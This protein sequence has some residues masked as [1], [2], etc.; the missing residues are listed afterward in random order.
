MNMLD[1]YHPKDVYKIKKEFI[2]LALIQ[3][4]YYCENLVTLFEK[5]IVQ[6]T[7]YNHIL[8]I[9][10]K[11]ELEKS[12]KKMLT[13][14]ELKDLAFNRKK[15]ESNIV[16]TDFTSVFGSKYKKYYNSIFKKRIIPYLRNAI[17]H[18]KFELD[19]E[20]QMIKGIYNPTTKRKENISFLKFIDLHDTIVMIYLCIVKELV[21]GKI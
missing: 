15:S 8:L 16:I 7:R 11:K 13:Y 17:A 19:E 20:K 1:N 10:I 9:D 4:G 6:N 21:R 18:N 5:F 14:L 3:Y 2:F 12:S